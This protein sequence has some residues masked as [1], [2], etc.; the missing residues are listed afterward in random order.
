MNRRPTF[1]R[2]EASD[3]LTEAGLALARTADVGLDET[4]ALGFTTGVLLSGVLLGQGLF[5]R[6]YGLDLRTGNDRLSRAVRV[7]AV[8]ARKLARHTVQ[9]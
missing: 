6:R 9:P 5:A 8:F 2:Q 3:L 1:T 7:L 4:F